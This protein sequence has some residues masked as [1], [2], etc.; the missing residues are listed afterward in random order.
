MAW[1]GAPAQRASALCLAVRSAEHGVPARKGGV[2]TWA[3][4]CFGMEVVSCYPRS[5]AGAGSGTGSSA[6]G[7]FLHLVTGWWRC[8]LVF[9]H[10]C[11]H[12]GMRGGGLVYTERAG[13]LFSCIS[14]GTHAFNR[15]EC[16]GRPVF[17]SSQQQQQELTRMGR[18]QGPAS[19]R[20]RRE[21][22]RGRQQCRG[23]PQTPAGIQAESQGGINTRGQL[24]SAGKA[25]AKKVLL[26]Q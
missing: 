5:A 18:A 16:P 17:T 15:K 13:S 3:P 9:T 8:A 12:R 19:N 4:L 11:C 14:C 10:S 2:G 26:W 23:R 20:P 22:K 6:W 1:H 24:R 21:L 7:A 25:V